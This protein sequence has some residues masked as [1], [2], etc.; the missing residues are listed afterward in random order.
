M[1]SSSTGT[2]AAA[3]WAQPILLQN[4]SAASL[5]SRQTQKADSPGTPP[6]VQKLRHAT[7]EFESLLITNLWKSMKSTI[8]SAEDGD[9]D[10]SDP[11]HDT[12]DDWGIRAMS[13]AVANAGGLG[14]G[15]ILF[16]HL[17]PLISAPERSAS[18]SEAA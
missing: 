10:S 16:H 12:L 9:D 14:L 2:L 8:G 18:G 6:R 3:A 15:R 17:A 5:T 11:A 7:A 1:T 13:Q 4:L